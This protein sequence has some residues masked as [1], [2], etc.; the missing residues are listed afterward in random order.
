MCKSSQEGGQRCDPWRSTVKA[1]TQSTKTGEMVVIPQEMRTVVSEHEDQLSKLNLVRVGENLMRVEPSGK[2]EVKL[3]FSQ[4]EL[5][6]IERIHGE[7][8]SAELI[9]RE[10]DKFLT[11]FEQRPELTAEELTALFSD[12]GRERQHHQEAVALERPK[13]TAGKLPMRSPYDSSVARRLTFYVFTALLNRINPVAGRLFVDS[14]A[15]VRIVLL[16]RNPYHHALNAS[17]AQVK[18]R[19]AFLKSDDP[20]KKALVTEKAS[21]KEQA[22][23]ISDLHRELHARLEVVQHEVER[24]NGFIETKKREMRELKASKDLSPDVKKRELDQMEK[25]VNSRIGYKNAQLAKVYELKAEQR[26]VL[27]WGQLLRDK[28]LECQRAQRAFLNSLKGS[29]T[30]SKRHSAY[31]QSNPGILTA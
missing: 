25:A 28:D 22:L 21:I 7:P 29:Y 14:H 16:S 27:E 19:E 1:L 26:D 9:E 8:L 12:S 15:L 6:Q 2:R 18:L 17:E 5:D 30:A 11:E 24:A 10:M 4:S 13:G 31:R 20:R 23:R 3:N